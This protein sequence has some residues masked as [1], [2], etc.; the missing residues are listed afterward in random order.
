[1]GRFVGSV[2]KSVGRVGSG[3]RTVIDTTASSWSYM[4]YNKFARALV[5]ALS[6]CGFSVYGGLL[7]P[8]TALGTVP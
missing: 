7:C 4:L 5:Y 6:T 3:Q 8:K 2:F 1:M